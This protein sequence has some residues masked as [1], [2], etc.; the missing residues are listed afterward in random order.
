MFSHQSRFN[1]WYGVQ[2]LSASGSVQDLN[3]PGVGERTFGQRA[4]F[5]FREAKYHLNLYGDED[6]RQRYGRYLCREV[7]RAGGE[8]VHSIR[9]LLHHQDLLYPEEA[10]RRGTHLEPEIFT[11]TLNEFSCLPRG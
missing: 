1:W 2:A 7:A 10:R 11:R 8:P 4:L 9:F 6:L 5:D 3:V